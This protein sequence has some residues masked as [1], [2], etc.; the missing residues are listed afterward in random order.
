MKG[1]KITNSNIAFVALVFLV[2]LG[3][4]LGTAWAQ[5]ARTGDRGGVSTPETIT[6][7]P[8][9]E[10]QYVQ[11]PDLIGKTEEL[12]KEELAK[13]GL[14]AGK[15]QFTTLGKGKPDTVV[16]QKP[17]ATARV[18][19]G[20]TVDLWVLRERAFPKAKAPEKEPAEVTPEVVQ[21]GKKVYLKFPQTV[22][23][24]TIY[25][26]K[27][28]KLQQFNKGKRF[29]ITESVLATKAGLIKVVFS[30]KPKGK[31]KGGVLKGGPPPPQFIEAL[32]NLSHLEHLPDLIR[33][34]AI[35]TADKT[36][37]ENGEPG[38][39][40]IDGATTVGT[41]S[42]YG[43][44]DYYAD[45]S[46]PADFLRITAGS[47]G[48]GTFF[49]I[50][51]LV[52][53]VELLLYDPTTAYIATSGYTGKLWIAVKPN[54][55]F[56]V[57]VQPTGYDTTQYTISISSRVINDTCEP[58]D[59]IAQ[60]K[61]FHNQILFL[62]NVMDNAGNHVGINDWY[63]ITWQYARK[64]KLIVRYAGLPDYDDVIIYLYEPDSGP[65]DAH[66]A[67]ARGDNN[68][69]ELVV[70]LPSMYY[71]GYPD[72]RFPFPAGEWKIQV[73]NS[74]AGDGIYPLPYGKGDAPSCFYRSSGYW[75]GGSSIIP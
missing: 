10:V 15:V 35:M 55:T 68:G 18:A 27:G 73:T 49:V 34:I 20:S 60:A 41:G 58:N 59:T 66:V 13:A 46:D 16:K 22:K 9:K 37:I 5:K 45:P 56:Y 53:D 3:L 12:A 36:T 40:E 25:D 30:P 64:M 2:G 21:K 6:A 62:C 74:T 71:P 11:V 52:G 14:K 26:D 54:V 31:P 28:N 63:K 48:F 42:Y 7:P 29:E 38:N 17:T 19:Q 32:I 65:Y 8:T 47:G 33:G 75:L 43:E 50:K 67:S 24:V 51:V 57:E 1:F 61:D 44:L 23:D 72:P 69:V 4:V 70:D 39:D